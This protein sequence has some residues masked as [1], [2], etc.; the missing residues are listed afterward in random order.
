MIDFTPQVAA[1]K[2]EFRERGAALFGRSVSGRGWQAGLSRAYGI[3]DRRVR[4]YIAEPPTQWLPVPSWL[5]SALRTGVMAK[6]EINVTG[7]K[8]GTGPTDDRDEAAYR[9]LSP[10]LDTVVQAGC[11]AGWHPAEVTTAV[12]NRLA[13]IMIDGAGAQA[14]EDAFRQAILIL[15]TTP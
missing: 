2:A 15:P 3:S 12:L 6:R 11:D 9:A 1:E 4:L 5:L 8:P 14:T 13:E 7:P 10:A